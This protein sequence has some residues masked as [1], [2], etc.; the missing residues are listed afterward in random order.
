MEDGEEEFWPRDVMAEI[1][2]RFLKIWTELF[3]VGEKRGTI[4]V[5]GLIVRTNITHTP[6]DNRPDPPAGTKLTQH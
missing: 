4:C 1:A 3:I 6:P 2:S 5:S